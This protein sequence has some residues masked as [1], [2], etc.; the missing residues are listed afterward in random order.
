MEWGGFCVRLA[1]G[2]RQDSGQ[3]ETRWRVSLAHRSA[4]LS[5][6]LV[7]KE[8]PMDIRLKRAVA[9]C[10]LAFWSYADA[11]TAF[12]NT[13]EPIHST[14]TPVVIVRE[15]WTL[16]GAV[17][18]IKEL[19]IKMPFIRAWAYAEAIDRYCFPAKS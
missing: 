2:G 11:A 19:W 10:I 18:G 4:I 12:E 15:N 16:E 7:D 6:R 3:P 14:T 1:T 5:H 8:R 17:E 13:A 9:V